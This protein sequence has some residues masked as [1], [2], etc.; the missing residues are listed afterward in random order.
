MSGDCQNLEAVEQTSYMRWI[1]DGLHKL[2][3]RSRMQVEYEVRVISICVFELGCGC[4][5]DSRYKKPPRY[6]VFRPQPSP[7]KAARRPE[8]T[9]SGRGPVVLRSMR[10]SKVPSMP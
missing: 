9:E 4:S 6:P 5:Q 8:P 10:P 1:F 7:L 3:F 2:C